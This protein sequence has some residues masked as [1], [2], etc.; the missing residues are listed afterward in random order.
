MFKRLQLTKILLHTFLIKIL[1]NMV[2]IH[3]SKFLRLLDACAGPTFEYTCIVRN[4][5]GT[6]FP[7][8]ASK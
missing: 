5:G 1:N 6:K 2:S 3:S 4:F 7:R 8:K